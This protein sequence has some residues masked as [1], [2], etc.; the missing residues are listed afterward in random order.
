[1]FHQGAKGP[2]ING[3]GNLEARVGGS[4]AGI[5]EATTPDVAVATTIFSDCV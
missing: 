2:I 5:I 1:M 4:A 3:E